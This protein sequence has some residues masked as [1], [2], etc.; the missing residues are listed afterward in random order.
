MSEQ[1]NTDA[2]PVAEAIAA[3][4]PRWRVGT[5]WQSASVRADAKNYTASYDNILLADP[6]P[7]GLREKIRREEAKMR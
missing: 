6:T 2:D 7:A 3:E 5:V 4:F 1:P